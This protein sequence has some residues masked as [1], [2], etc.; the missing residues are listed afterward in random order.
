MKGKLKFNI[1]SMGKMPMSQVEIS[2]L[3]A[4]LR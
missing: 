1:A 2:A 4:T 3:S